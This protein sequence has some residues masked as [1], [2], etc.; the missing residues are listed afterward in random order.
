MGNPVNARR[1]WLRLRFR[2]PH[3]VHA[4]LLGGQYV[5]LPRIAD[6]HGMFRGHI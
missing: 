2:D 3:R 5:L 4:Q 1:E 6:V